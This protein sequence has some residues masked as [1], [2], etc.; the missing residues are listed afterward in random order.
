MLRGQPKIL[1]DSAPVVSCAL[2][3]RFLQRLDEGIRVQLAVQ[4]ILLDVIG[5]EVGACPVVIQGVYRPV[6]GQQE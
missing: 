4:V 2:L 1:A 3:R 5:H 6:Y